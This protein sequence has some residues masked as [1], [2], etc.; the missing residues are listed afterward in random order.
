[1]YIDLLVFGSEAATEITLLELKQLFHFCSGIPWNCIWTTAL[2]VQDFLRTVV[3]QLLSRSLYKVWH[4]MLSARNHIFESKRP[5]R[6]INLNL[7]ICRHPESCSCCKSSW[8]VP[9]LHNIL[10]VHSSRACNWIAW[11]LLNPAN[12]FNWKFETCSALSSNA[13]FCLWYII[14]HP[15][16][17]L[18][19]WYV[20]TCDKWR[21]KA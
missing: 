1:M 16:Q 3:I 4:V 17:L 6:S 11:P 8:V 18:C 9:P 12:I 13:I 7:G 5:I 10:H 15:M 19:L 21:N 2:Y 20:A 14:G